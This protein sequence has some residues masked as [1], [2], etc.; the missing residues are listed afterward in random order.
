MATE[1]QGF[2]QLPP[3]ST[4]KKSA[5]A[6]RLIIAFEGEATSPR[7]AQDDIITGGTSGATGRVVGIQRVEFP[8]GE[9]EI[10]LELGSVVGTFVTSE[11]LKI[12]PTVYCQTK[13]D[14][15]LDSIYYQRNVI[16]DHKTPSNRLEIDSL[17]SAKVT[18]SETR[19]TV[20]S[21]G[22]LIT[23]EATSL[24]Q[25]VHAYDGLD[26]TF[27]RESGGTGFLAYASGERA[28]TLNTGGTASGAFARRTSHYYHPYQPGNMLRYISSIVCGDTGKD[29]VIRRWGLFDENNGV[30]FEQNGSGLFTVIRSNT[31]GAV[32]D[33]KTPQADW[34]ADKLDGGI[35]F[36]IDVSKANL[37][38]IDTQ[39]LGAGTVKFGVWSDLGEKT[40]AHAVGNPNKNVAPYMRQA[41]LPVRW[42]CYNDNTAASSSE[43]KSICTVVQNIGNVKRQLNSHSICTTTP[44]VITAADGEV[45]I[46]SLRPLTT[47]NSIDNNTLT[48][49]SDVSIFNSDAKAMIVRLRRGVL[50][51][52]E[53]FGTTLLPVNSTMEIDEAASGLFNPGI[54]IWSAVVASGQVKDFDFLA[55]KDSLQG[56]IGMVL[57]KDQATQPATLITAEVVGVGGTEVTC[58][59]GWKEIRS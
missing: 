12:G 15:A 19:P 50:P 37:Y 42:E 33:T 3:D 41:T 2:I 7:F 9:G 35:D 1:E 40:T 38:W 26:T 13:A 28:V 25:Y 10:F 43:L 55:S 58:T 36:N 44:K 24:F 53:A 32:V 21:F 45:P 22:G 46:I 49:F 59:V 30:F 16:V 34:N 39:W 54:E 57:L 18:F 47:Y 4:G 52:G 56:D 27:F 20:S 48:L 23:E 17:G 14:A 8:T 11:D 5:A 31:T 29:D 51:S 6:G